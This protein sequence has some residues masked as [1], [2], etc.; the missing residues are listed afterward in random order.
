MN[1][2]TYYVACFFT[3]VSAVGVMAGLTSLWRKA[4]TPVPNVT[5]FFGS[6]IGG[7]SVINYS[8]TDLP[9][10]LMAF[11]AY[12]FFVFLWALPH[13]LLPM[14]PTDSDDLDELSFNRGNVFCIAI[15][16]ILVILQLG[17]IVALPAL[18]LLP[19]WIAV[20]GIALFFLVN[21]GL[22]MLING[23]EVEY[24]SDPQY[25]QA[26][27]EHAHEQWIFINGVAAG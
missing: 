19:V 13:V 3:F 20:L 24:H 9:W 18:I 27:P 1:L 6:Q 17:F 7:R 22:C 12:Y 14:T 8:Y 23:K 2:S 16:F 21:H 4:K 10:R 25:A 26:S 11:D 15:H 5:K